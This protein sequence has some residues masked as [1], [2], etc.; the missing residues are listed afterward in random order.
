MTGQRL[1]RT[2]WVWIRLR[3]TRPQKRKEKTNK[4]RKNNQTQQKKKRN[5]FQRRKKEKWTLSSV[6]LVI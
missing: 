5:E 6:I 3:K 2:T 4:E 1:P